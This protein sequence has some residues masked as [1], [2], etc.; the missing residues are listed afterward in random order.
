MI[1]EP[2]II[3]YRWFV[4]QNIGF[5]FRAVKYATKQTLKPIS[6]TQAQHPTP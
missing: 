4:P 5:V 3:L 6:G 2:L 1:R